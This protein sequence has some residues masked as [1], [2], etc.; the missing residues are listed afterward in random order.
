MDKERVLAYYKREDIRKEMV[1]SALDREVATR[2]N[3]S[4]GKRPDVLHYPND[5]L[6]CAKSGATSFH[7]SE[8]RWRDPMQLSTGMRRKEQDDLRIGWDLVLDID[9]PVWEFSRLITHLFV[10]ALIKHGIKSVCCKFSGNKGF[11]IGVPFEALP[12][13]ID[14]VATSRLF[15]EWP[16]DIASYLLEYINGPETDYEFTRMLSPEENIEKIMSLTGK[17]REELT[18]LRCRDC[19]SDS[20]VK[21]EKRTYEYVCPGCQKRISIDND[22]GFMKCEACGIFMEKGIEKGMT[23]CSKCHGTH[24][25]PVFE[26]S[27]IVD[28]DT[29]LISSRHLYRMP[30]S[31]HEKSGLASLPIDPQKVLEFE[32]DMARPQI[33]SI[34]GFR[35]LDTAESSASETELLF[36][37]V[38]KFTAARDAREDAQKIHQYQKNAKEGSFDLPKSAIPEEFFSPC[39]K[40]LLKGLEDGRKRALFI[41]VNYLTCL[42][43]GHDKITE[44]V[45]SWNRK[46]KEPLRQALVTSHVRYH[47]ARKSDVPPPNCSTSYYKDLG[48]CQPDGL[49]SKIKNPV[50]YS[51][52][53]A[54]F[55]MKKGKKKS[56]SKQKKTQSRDLEKVRHKE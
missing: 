20:P 54:Y 14:G 2:Y 33:L 38:R 46:N 18:V 48:L 1:L 21:E 49:C 6:E 43:Y 34:S 36:K 28:L 44:M 53:R 9:C 10:Q 47:H 15:P 31:L 40:Q 51:K 19:G 45:D 22:P 3:L 23:K 17:S 32:K 12:G 29:L 50:Q 39:V 7:V 42:G 11:H 8:E 27:S 24:L 52:R 55:L 16:R 41:L 5:I 4:F 30:Y 26:L 56:R 37:K 13:E 35:F 25:F